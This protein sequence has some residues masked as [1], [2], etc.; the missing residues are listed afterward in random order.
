M[1]R[2][3]MAA[4]SVPSTR[5]GLISKGSSPAKPAGAV[6]AERAR[7]TDSAVRVTAMEALPIRFGPDVDAN[8]HQAYQETDTIALTTPVSG[9]RYVGMASGSSARAQRWV[10]QGVVSSCFEAMRR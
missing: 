7:S 6:T 9:S 8:P 10:I 5:T 3:V 4:I 1:S 2:P